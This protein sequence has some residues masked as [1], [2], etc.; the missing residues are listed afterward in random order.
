[1]NADHLLQVILIQ[2]IVGMGQI[3]TKIIHSMTNFKSMHKMFV[4]TDINKI[5]PIGAN[6]DMI[7]TSMVKV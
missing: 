1:M 3:W 5:N 6:E 7:C 2:S 4:A